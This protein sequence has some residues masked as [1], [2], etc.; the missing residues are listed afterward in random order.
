MKINSIKPKSNLTDQKIRNIKNSK[1]LNKIT[2][3]NYNKMFIIL[4]NLLISI[5]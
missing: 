4:I 5:S 1:K 3:F 2:N